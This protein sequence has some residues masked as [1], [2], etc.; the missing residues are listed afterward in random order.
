MRTFLKYGAMFIV[1]GCL[2]LTIFHWG[3]ELGRPYGIALFGWLIVLIENVW[4]SY[5][6]KPDSTT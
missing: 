2:L 1:G 4:P 5:G 3:T 6:Q